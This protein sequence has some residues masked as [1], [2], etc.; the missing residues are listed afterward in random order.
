[1]SRRTGR[2]NVLSPITPSHQRRSSKDS[3]E[4]GKDDGDGHGDDKSKQ[5]MSWD[6]PEAP[7]G[8]V[9]DAVATFLREFLL[10]VECVGN[11]SP[12]QSEH[13]TTTHG[14]KA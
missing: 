5:N 9:H 11:C 1:M 8:G 10:G 6:L 13:P 4:S 7:F 3:N 12:M 2:G 14:P